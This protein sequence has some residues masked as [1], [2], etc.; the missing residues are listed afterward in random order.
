VG[1]ARYLQSV[2]IVLATDGGTVVGEEIAGWFEDYSGNRL[3]VKLGEVVTVATFAFVMD[4]HT[5]CLGPCQ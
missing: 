3:G 5:V 1:V 2:S 4:I